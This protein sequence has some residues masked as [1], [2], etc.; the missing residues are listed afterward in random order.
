MR[1]TLTDRS[2]RHNLQVTEQA[3][4]HDEGSEPFSVIARS[5]ATKQ[6]SLPLPQNGGGT[7][8]F[9]VSTPASLI[10]FAHFLVSASIKLRKCS[11][12]S[13]ATVRP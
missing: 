4:G 6:S 1:D 7:Y 10:T 3:F 9:V 5:E 12:V 11:G 8:Y 2:Y 13:P